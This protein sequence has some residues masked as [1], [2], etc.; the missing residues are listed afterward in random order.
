MSKNSFVCRCGKRFEDPKHKNRKF[1]SAECSFKY[2]P[3]KP[4]SGYF[5]K[6]HAQLTFKD[7]SKYHTIICPCGI[8]IYC[9]IKRTMEKK[10]CSKEC[11][12]KYRPGRGPHS[13][14]TKRK[15]QLA[16]K[17]IHA[18]HPERAINWKGGVSF[19]PGYKSLMKKKSW[20]NTVGSHTKDEWE[21][22]KVM[23]GFTCPA[24][25]RIEPEIQ[26]TQD[27][28]IPLIKGGSDY[29]ENIQPLCRSCNTRK[30]VK[31]TRYPNKFNQE[32]VYAKI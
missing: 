7:P 31:T 3:V 13:E 4:N 26:L 21:V 11:W 15:I 9:R 22:V 12:Y 28:I 10:Y 16:H 17:R 8:D 19:V 6:G 25:D 2:R 24:C 30:M 1:C 32:S 20:L 23:Y 27:H 29:I 5:Q 14:E 18:G